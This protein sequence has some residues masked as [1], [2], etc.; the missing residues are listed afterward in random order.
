MTL[1]QMILQRIRTKNNH[2]LHVLP[3]AKS[4]VS[5]FNIPLTSTLAC[6]SQSIWHNHRH[7]VSLSL[8]ISPC[9]RVIQQLDAEPEGLKKVEED[10]TDVG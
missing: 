1:L 6:K 10:E 9:S 5:C 2:L 4:H 7:R 3:V 8:P